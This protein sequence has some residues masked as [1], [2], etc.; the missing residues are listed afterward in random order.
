MSKP[1]P[2]KKIA[3]RTMQLTCS[4]LI[5]ALVFAITSSAFD[6]SAQSVLE[7]KVTLT[8]NDTDV[9]SVLR[10]IEQ[11][12]EARF[13]YNSKLIRSNRKISLSVSQET[14]V[15]VLKRVLNPLQIEYEVSQ[16]V[17]LLNPAPPAKEKEETSLISRPAISAALADQLITGT[18]T[19][20]K[21]D[22][23]PGVSVVLKGTTTGTTTDGTGKYSLNVPDPS[24]TLVFSFVGYASE[25]VSVG[26][27]TV[28][29]VALKASEA[30]L[31]EVVVVGY[32]TQK[33]KD[34]T[35]A[36]STVKAEDFAPGANSDA[37]QLLKG[38]A[39]GV[40]VTQTSSAP[41][42]GLKVLI[43]GA[44][45][46][47]SSNGVL[48][49][50]DGLP[51]VDPSSLSPGDIA[52]ID[53]L[54]DASSAAIYGTRAAN[55]V[56]LITTNKGKEGKSV[57]SYSTYF[58]SQKVNKLV[59]VLGASDYMR[60]VNF[61]LGA[62]N[63]GPK[64]T[65][66]E[67]AAAGE[68]TNWQREI[69][70]QALVQNHQLSMSG[71]SKNTN[72]YIGLNYFNQNG[73]VIGSGDKKYN[74]R[75]NIE[76][77]PLEKL[78]VSA[79]INFTRENQQIIPSQL[80]DG[81]LLV[82]AIRSDPTYSPRPDSTGRYTQIASTATENPVA[83]ALGVS[84]VT[85]SSR[86]YGTL[87]SDYS[88]TN[89]LTA[90]LRLG[91]ET[92]S[93]R[94]D[95]Y[96]SRLT[97]GGLGAGGVAN[98]NSSEYNHWLAEP[99]IRYENIFAGKHA[100]SALAGTT[101]EEFVTRGLTA[102]GRGF[103]S[104]VTGTNLLQS[105]D[106]DVGDNIA[107]SKFKNQLN[108]Y[109]GRLTYGFD[110]RYLL[111]ASFRVD[112]SSRFATGNKYAFFPSGSIGWVLS[113]E[114]FMKSLG[115]VNFL[116]LRIG[117]GELGN[118]GINNFETKETLVSGGN[119]IFNDAV[120]QGVLPA[121][122]P[123][124]NLR[125]ET[126][127]EVNVGLDY[128]LVK[129]R[130]SGS[131]DYFY[132]KTFDQLFIK[133]LPSVVG[134]SS[135]R[136]NAGDVLNS[137]IDLAIKSLNIDKALKWTTSLTLSYVKNQVTGLPSFTQ[138]IIGGNAGNFVSGYWIVRQGD[139]LRSFYGYQI[140]GIFQTVDE[141]ASSAKPVQQGYLP[142][143]PRFRDVNGD[144]VINVND[145]VILG[146]SIPDYTF[147]FRN[148]ITYK[149]LSL[150]VFINGVQG[151]ETF[152]NNVAESLYP[153]N[154][155]TNTNSRYF[156][157]RWTPENPSSTLPSG[158]NYSLYA[159]GFAVNSLTVTDASYARLKNVTLGYNVPLTGKS[160]SLVRV[161]VSADNLLTVTSFEG[162]DPEASVQGESLDSRAY[163]SYPLARVIR[164]GFDI[165]F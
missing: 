116:K 127:K 26:A 86:L 90:T 2:L 43:R 70:R 160:L 158:V 31:N 79:G 113:E 5:L 123:N 16:N 37:S 134:F 94:T 162:S 146:K 159:G 49:V 1:L 48:Y 10:Q 39:A 139:A 137:G 100:F 147:G 42:A 81:G 98:V 20:E 88:L 46:I 24:A 15:S 122:L 84:N 129:S 30:T 114:P 165:K 141:V 78:K 80:T 99:L 143:M 110:N 124:P 25:E 164:A 112:G 9:R 140:D 89:H 135:V 105:G 155:F 151:V 154:T 138:Q 76:T 106:G 77:R 111:T 40:I 62:R 115:A 136:T 74:A 126:T 69:F 153:I 128:E 29:N 41:G 52:S 102:S 73:V 17:I 148:T 150:D 96:T 19:D 133:P 107:S 92:N 72:Y 53:V 85:L 75:I 22:Q 3:I 50:V 156:F 28:V 95:A 119:S 87:T 67:I 11:Q 132:R 68:G 103:L 152:D 14:L 57:L 104:D 63:L 82:S 65:D 97:Q 161:Y 130:L 7:Q 38:T 47:N 131:I 27:K 13:V 18:V 142:G 4:Q 91:V 6:T 61:R 59:D 34:L 83:Q 93:G 117:Y 35:G 56:V 149:N 125:W 36:I 55:G 8:L 54:K 51:G 33:K 101:F 44:G 71:G 32:G 45:S 12:T 64:F 163:N 118:Q 108:G 58:G 23:L 60:L 66:P 121:R 120:V 145:R 157:D 21:G 109:I 144:G